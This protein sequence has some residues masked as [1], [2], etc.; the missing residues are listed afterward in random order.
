[1]NNVQEDQEVNVGQPDELQ[2][3]STND[4]TNPSDNA[5][6]NKSLEILDEVRVNDRPEDKKNEDEKKRCEPTNENCEENIT[7]FFSGS[8]NVKE[9]DKIKQEFITSITRFLKDPLDLIR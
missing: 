9:K 8:L 3:E 2:D 4:L 6:H 7:N 5:S 1:M